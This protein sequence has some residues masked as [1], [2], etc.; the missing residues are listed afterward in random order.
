[1]SFTKVI[2]SGNQLEIYEYEKSLSPRVQR[3]KKNVGRYPKLTTRRID[4]AYRLKK[5]FVR[6]VRSNLVGTEPPLFFTFT[7]VEVIRIE[8]AYRLFTECVSRLRR[9]YGKCFRYIA[10]PEF[11]K[12]GAVHFHV[13]VWGIGQKEIIENERVY[14]TIQNIWSRGYVDC[15]LTDG[16]PALAGYLGKYMHKALL[17]Q[18]LLG[19]KSYCASRN[20]LRT[21]SLN[22]AQALNFS[23]EIWGIDEKVAIPEKERE[24]DTKWLGRCRYRSFL[25]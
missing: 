22:F 14:R 12:R 21:V 19:Q 8:R 2:Q 7:M 18:R 4:N 17:D 15:I 24:F 10:V 13:L 9:Q 16:H 25:P 5:T 23:Q 3:K 20:V 11:Q 6:L 1:M